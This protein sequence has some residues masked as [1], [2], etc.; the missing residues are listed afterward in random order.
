M[1]YL[2]TS[3][4]YLYQSIGRSIQEHLGNIRNHILW[5]TLHMLSQ[6][7]RCKLM[8]RAYLL[9]VIWGTFHL[10]V[11]W[12]VF[13]DLCCIL[14]LH[15]SMPNRV[16]SGCYCLY[17]DHACYCSKMR[18]NWTAWFCMLHVSVH[19]SF[20]QAWVYACWENQVWALAQSNVNYA[21]NATTP[22][23]NHNWQHLTKRTQRNGKLKEEFVNLFNEVSID[24][25]VQNDRNSVFLI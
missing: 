11:V 5:V 4:R 7:N 10:I 13:M 20:A 19:R 24:L 17:L 16:T 8:G 18:N 3:L 22:K 25:S 12:I 9:A 23:I 14:V 15:N 1:L 6:R 21:L 2:S